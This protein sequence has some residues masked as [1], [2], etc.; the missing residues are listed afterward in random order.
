LPLRRDRVVVASSTWG[1]YSDLCMTALLEVD[2][3]TAPQLHE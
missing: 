1:G 2:E 3:K